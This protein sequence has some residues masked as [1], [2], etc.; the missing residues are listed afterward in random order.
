MKWVYDELSTGKWFIDQ[1]WKAA[2]DKGLKTGRKNFWQIIRN[3]IY[4][5]RIPIAKYKDEEAHTVIGQHK[6]IVSERIFYKAMDVLN[7]RNKPKK[8]TI[9]SPDALPLRGFLICPKCGY[10][11]SGSASKGYSKHYH[12]YH[13]FSKC[14]VRYNA[15]KVNKFFV[16]ELKNILVLENRLIDLSR[17]KENIGELIGKA[18]GL[19]KNLHET[20]IVADSEGKRRLISSIYPQKLTFDGTQHRTVRMNEAVRVLGTLKAVFEGKKKGQTKQKFDLP[21]M[22]AGS[23]IELPTSG[24]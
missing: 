10:M 5:G 1:I 20:Y 4:C 23:R 17:E 7:G 3:P 16:E 19:L 24:L 2:S 21:T 9:S 12:Y 8:T 15:E 22:V 13:C 11:L 6:A 18:T 14:G